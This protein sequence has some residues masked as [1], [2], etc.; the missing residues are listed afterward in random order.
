MSRGLVFPRSDCLL[1]RVENMLR[2]IR[3]SDLPTLRDILKERYA[4]A[5]IHTAHDRLAALQRGPYKKL[6]ILHDWVDHVGRTS[7]IFEVSR[8]SPKCLHFLTMLMLGE[9]PVNRTK[10]YF[11]HRTH[12]RSFCNSSILTLVQMGL[13]PLFHK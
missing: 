9:L 1:G 2:R 10:A 6:R 8:F 3:E 11:A 4:R 7:S 5:I 12:L 13:S